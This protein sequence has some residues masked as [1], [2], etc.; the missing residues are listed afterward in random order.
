LDPV[1]TGSLN[2]GIEYKR[3]L[4]ETMDKVLRRKLLV[5]TTITTAL[6]LGIIATLVVPKRYTAEAYI[7]EGFAASDSAT[8]TRGSSSGRSINVDA[9]LLVETRSRLFE[10]RQLARRVVKDIELGGIRLGENKSLFASWV[11][12]TFYGDASASPEYQED[13]AATKL[14]RDLS[15]KTEPRVYHI[16]LQYTARDPKLAAFITNTF[17]AEFLRTTKLETLSQQLGSALALLSESLATLG[18][19]HPKV[20]EAKMR[21][22]SADS[23]MKELLSKTPKEILKTA[24]ENI[25][26]AEASAVPSSPKPLLFI[27]L[28]LLVGLLAGVGIAIWRERGRHART[29]TRTTVSSRN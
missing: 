15:I 20:I 25:T 24:G 28:A 27:G 1:H 4:A 23:L 10:S 22:A 3:A 12:A 21:V 26:L 8:A 16:V 6:A 14:L 5:I 17:L 2:L 18:E 7:H 13:L 9:S 29:D 19:K 11:E